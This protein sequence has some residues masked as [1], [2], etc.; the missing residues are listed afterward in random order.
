MNIIT[1]RINAGFVTIYSNWSNILPY[2]IKVKKTFLEKMQIKSDLETYCIKQGISWNFDF[3]VSLDIDEYLMPMD[4]SRSDT[5][6]DIMDQFYNKSKANVLRL[7]KYNFQQAPHTLEPVNLLTIEA[8]QTRMETTRAMTYFKGT[9]KKLAVRLNGKHLGSIPEV[10]NNDFFVVL[11]RTGKHYTNIT[12]EFVS[13]CCTLHGC[14][15]R[16]DAF[17]EKN[18]KEL[19]TLFRKKNKYDNDLVLYHYSRSLEKYGLK[20]KT[21]ETAT[22]EDPNG[23]NVIHFMERNF[24]RQTDRS[25]LDYSCQLRKNLAEMT[26]KICVQYFTQPFTCMTLIIGLTCQNRRAAFFPSR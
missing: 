17:C 26:S 9:T 2:D 22:G 13:R 18:K 23:Y 1:F 8:Y 7:A 21:W 15:L 19:G 5:V 4:T 6:V 14:R 20:S 25:A 16:D 12:Q 10:F 24:G 3:F 11:N